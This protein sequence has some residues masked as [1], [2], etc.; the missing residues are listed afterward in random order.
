[1]V[2]IERNRQEVTTLQSEKHGIQV[3]AYSL[4]EIIESFRP[5]VVI[6][7]IEGGEYDF[8]ESEADWSIAELRRLMV[9]FHRTE[10][11]QEWLENSW[12]FRSPCWRPSKSL[13]EVT[14]AIALSHVTVTF[15]RESTERT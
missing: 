8:L 6:L 13:Q 5:T 3:K 7:D 2:V 15:Q 10:A 11:A 1:M 14:E 4:R 9:E 12:L